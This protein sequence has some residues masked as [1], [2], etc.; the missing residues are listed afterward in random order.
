MKNFFHWSKFYYN[1]VMFLSMGFL[2]YLLSY[3]KN[4]LCL[5][6]KMFSKNTGKQK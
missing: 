4:N 1:V 3:Y 2:S 5:L 6:W